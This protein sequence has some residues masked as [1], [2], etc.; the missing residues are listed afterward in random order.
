MARIGFIGVGNMGGPMLRNLIG[1]GHAVTAFD[2]VEGA[3]NAARDAGATLAAT[4]G[5]AA[6]AGE[7]VITM[8]PAGEHVRGPIHLNELDRHTRAR[9]A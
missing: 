1:A 8:L 5:D 2:V 4:A 7:I 9:S 3:R 6:A